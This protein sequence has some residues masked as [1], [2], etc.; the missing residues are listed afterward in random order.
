ME[1]KYAG[2]PRDDVSGLTISPHILP[3]RGERSREK[4][5]NGINSSVPSDGR[6]PLVHRGQ[7]VE[8]TCS[9]RSSFRRIIGIE[10]E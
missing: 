5:P 2:S 8:I 4:T 1:I 9:V 7:N 10:I 3:V 6:K